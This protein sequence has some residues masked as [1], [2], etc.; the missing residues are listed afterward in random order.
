MI[1]INIDPTLFHLGP[2]AFSWYGLAVAAGML[3]GIWLLLREA[4]RRGLPTEPALDLVFWIIAAGL[5]GARLLYVLDRWSFYAA[6]PTQ[7]FSIH[8]GGLSIM[9]AILGGGLTAA[10]LARRRGL[11][12]RRLFDAAAP[13]IVLGQA[14]GRFGC[15]VTGDTVG[16]PTD[17]GWGIVY[18]NPGARVPQLGV[19]YQPAFFY[20]QVWDVLVFAILWRLRWHVRGDGQLFAV[21]LGLYAVGKFAITFIRLD[22]V[23]FWGLQQSH[24][25]ALGL[26]MLAIGWSL[27]NRA[28]SRGSATPQLSS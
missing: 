2:L 27:W 10:L 21:Y 16:R 6:N 8:T 4:Q 11:P 26:L 19:A 5:V 14:I 28:Q 3:A 23:Y 12:V 22:P 20:E 15:L 13:G 1:T 7:I 9:G 25:V 18:M 17:G 24:F